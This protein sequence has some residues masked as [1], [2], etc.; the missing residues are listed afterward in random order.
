MIYI[1]VQLLLLFNNK[2]IPCMYNNLVQI[3]SLI[4]IC[5]CA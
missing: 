1:N 5:I 2:H 4:Y 3:H